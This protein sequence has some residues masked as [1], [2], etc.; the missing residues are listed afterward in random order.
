VAESNA[1]PP[2]NQTTRGYENIQLVLYNNSMH[3][4]EPVIK[5]NA[6][7]MRRSEEIHAKTL[8]NPTFNITDFK[9]YT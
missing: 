1:Q 4:K 8:R 2:K 9:H 6:N 7:K 5:S 3:K